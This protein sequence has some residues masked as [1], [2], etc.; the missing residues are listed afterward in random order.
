MNYQF[1]TDMIDMLQTLAI[2]ILSLGVI[3]LSRK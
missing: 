1:A 3:Y 2:I